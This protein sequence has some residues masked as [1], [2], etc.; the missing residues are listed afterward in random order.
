MDRHIED[1]LSGDNPE[2]DL[3]KMPEGK[4]KDMGYRIVNVLKES[5]PMNVYSREQLWGRITQ[6][7]EEEETPTVSRSPVSRLWKWAAAACILLVLSYFTWDKMLM[8]SHTSPLVAAAQKNKYTFEDDKDISLHGAKQQLAVVVEEQSVL[9]VPSLDHDP[10]TKDIGAF[11]TL[12]VPYGKRIEVI[13]PDSSKVWVNAGSQ[14]TFPKEFEKDKREVYLEGEAF[15]DIVSDPNA[16]PF[17]VET[18]DMR[19]T[20]LGTTFNVSSYQD[21]TFSSAVLMSGRV[22]LEGIGKTPFRA[23]ILEPGNAAVLNRKSQSLHIRKEKAEDHMSWTNKQL[24]L[25][26]DPLPNILVRLGRV[27]N[28]KITVVDDTPKG[29]DTFSGRLDLSQPLTD[30]LINL[31]KPNEY[32]IVEEER[33]ITITRKQ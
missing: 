9:H 10:S 5:K 22:E 32:T 11:M 25:K 17:F 3:R 15:F 19:I 29:E 30:L 21:D 23:T 18:T 4:S 27:F 2:K 28:T 16:V 31:Y 7:I 20:V 6:S 24:I 14:L 12:S 8:Q 13:L 26:N 33:R 1:I